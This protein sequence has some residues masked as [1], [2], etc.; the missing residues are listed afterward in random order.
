MSRIMRRLPAC[1]GPGAF[2]VA[3][4]GLLL[5]SACAA[6]AEITAFQQGVSPAPDYSG[7]VDTFI[8]S[9][10]WAHDR[11]SRRPRSGTLS[12]PALMR[13][14]LGTLGKDR[15]V[16]RALLRVACASVPS[17]DLT[18]EVRTF[19][20]AWDATATWYEHTYKD[21]K[22]S[23][24]NNWTKPGGDLDGADFGQ[25]KPGLIAKAVVRGGPFG[26]VVEL[27]VTAVVA[28][29]VSGKR[30]NYG[31]H[32][33]AERG[34]FAIASAD[35]PIPAWRPRLI[36]EHYAANEQAA[37]GVKLALPEALGPK[38]KLSP[39][40]RRVIS[41]RR[42]ARPVRF[43]RNANCH[44]RDGHACGYAKQDP[45]YG[46][47]WGW[48]PRLRIGGTAG[49]LNH[50]LFRF[51]LSALPEKASVNRA[52]LRVCVDTSGMRLPADTMG[53]TPPEPGKRQKQRALA[54][55]RSRLSSLSPYSFGL[56]RVTDPGDWTEAAFDFRRRAPGQ[57]WAG[58]NLAAATEAAP[59]AVAHVGRQWQELLA[60]RDKIAETWLEWDVTRIVQA[61]AAGKVPN[62][63]LVLDGRLMGGEVTLFS[64]DWIEPD[65][66]P[67]LE[68]EV[69]PAPKAA[70]A[71]AL[72]P[73]PLLPEGDYWV[74]PMK[75]AHARWTGTPGT[76]GQYGDSITI[77]MAFWTPLL[78]GER[79]GA[80]PEMA[81]A[82]AT[83]RKVIHRP[84]WRHWK[85]GGWG[86]TGNMTID[87]AF[88]NV[89]AWQ[90]KMDPEVA[91][92]LFGTNDVGSGPHPPIYTEKYAAV[93]DR[94][95]A[96]GTIPIMTTLPPHGRQ[97]G[98][99]EGLRLVLDLRQ[100]A[101]AVAR[102]KKVPLIDFYAE[103]VKR[104]PKEWRKIMVPD[105]LHPSYP[106]EHRS[107]WT[108][109]GLRH[110]GYTLR[111][112]LTLKMWYGI[113]TKVL[114]P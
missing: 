44:Y 30:P 43:G 28:E 79:K 76:F 106:K 31:F 101:I 59:V 48:T 93:I 45:R 108:E 35:W 24:E 2:A 84:C 41:D 8:A 58:G 74:A 33:S 64:D 17:P 78:Y 70:P 97:V 25:G 67:Y 111:N 46:G 47:N 1:P 36:V 53:Q 80:T 49:D 75:A 94:M 32:I 92:I 88:R 73:E 21:A 114:K 39:L 96:D 23:D 29:W 19:A 62:R 60:A 98:S 89:D 6:R 20:R 3:L 65:R 22:K 104:Q 68:V 113:Y 42:R 34:G 54:R 112:Y 82:L 9:H 69:F 26:H 7:C 51:D 81:K 14:D 40:G 85:G 66:R 12:R 10:G 13:F 100:A 18:L 52:T 105:G 110:S 77:T 5:I 56:F 27:D 71:G 37:P 109:E 16:R 50:A 103:I 4:V 72:E 102:Q 11:P 87:W 83:A 99:A 57:P 15:R 55:F 63:G 38:C 91:A 107:D 90:K 86:N 95:L 61:W